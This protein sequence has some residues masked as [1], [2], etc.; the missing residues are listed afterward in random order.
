MM[1]VVVVSSLLV[2][3]L[4][5]QLGESAAAHHQISVEATP[6]DAEEAVEATKR[7]GQKAYGSL[8]R[9]QLVF[10]LKDK[11]EQHKRLR[12]LLQVLVIAGYV[13]AAMTL[14]YDEGKQI[15]AK[16]FDLPQPETAKKEVE[17][18]QT[19]LADLQKRLSLSMEKGESSAKREE[20]LKLMATSEIL[21]LEEQLRLL[22]EQM[23]QKEELFERERQAMQEVIDNLAETKIQKLEE[24]DT[25][26]RSKKHKSDKEKEA[27][28]QS[29]KHEK[30]KHKAD[31]EKAETLSRDATLEYPAPSPAPE[32]MG[33]SEGPG[34]SQAKPA[35]PKLHR[36][37]GGYSSDVSTE[38]VPPPTT[39][40]TEMPPTSEAST[41]E[42]EIPATSAPPDT[43]A[44]KQAAETAA[45]AGAGH[46]EDSAPSTPAPP[47]QPPQPAP[48]KLPRSRGFFLFSRQKSGD[49]KD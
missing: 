47:E 39:A 24:L 45:G 36:D 34:K 8:N 38:D 48:G 4:Q 22:K 46:P 31:K 43:P 1:R 5:K 27:E 20:E 40:A 15:A 3:L 14:F 11:E 28:K 10:L 2:L 37:S 49:K 13:L 21:R 29:K 9:A 44:G 12:R 18:L 6:E 19:R 30:A 17:R 23:K 42:S 35:R 26:K 33:P 41:T 32:A 16:L 7:W 25:K